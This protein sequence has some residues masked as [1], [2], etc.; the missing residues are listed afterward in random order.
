MGLAVVTVAAG[1]LPV[2]EVTAYG[3]AVTEAANARGIAVTKVTGGKPGL[4]VTFVTESGQV[5]PPLTPATLNGTNTLVAMS[6][7]NLTVTHNNT[8]TNAG[9][10]STSAKTAGKY[11]FEMTLQVTTGNVYNGI[12]V[13]S[14]AW[15]GTFS[16][17]Q[18]T[19]NL[20]GVIPAAVSSLIYSNGAS[21]GLSL[22]VASVGDVFCSAIDLT[23]RLAWVRKNNGNWNASG[24]ANPATGV[25]GVII[26]PTVSFAPYV[27]FS[28]SSVSTD[29][30]TAN[31]GASAFAGVVPSSYTPGWPA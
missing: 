9:V 15:S 2:V 23:A 16:S 22:G 21:T 3:L 26:A 30:I 13:M 20:T 25:G 1:G 19:S 8:S 24:T 6:N 14:S 18:T 29:A 5:V 11:Y 12:G 27:A 31:F 17:S 28:A 4:P 10:I 7:G